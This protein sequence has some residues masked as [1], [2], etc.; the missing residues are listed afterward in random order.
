MT[1]GVGVPESCHVLPLRGEVPRLGVIGAGPP[2]DRRTAG[3]LR[4]PP[5]GLARRPTTPLRLL[6]VTGWGRNG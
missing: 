1:G 2:L 3:G 6:D 5:G 4:A